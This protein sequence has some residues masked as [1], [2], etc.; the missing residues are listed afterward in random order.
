[1]PGFPVAFDEGVPDEKLAGGDR[2]DTVEV[3]RAVGDDRDAVEGDLLRGDDGAAVLGPAGLAVGPLDQVGG[4]RF[5]PFRLDAGDDA[6]PEPGGLD[7]LGGDH[8]VRRL[9]GERGAR[10]DREPGA[11]GAEVFGQRTAATLRGR[12]RPGS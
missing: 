9:A 4:D 8:P 12:A 11:A 5:D 10:E 1:M 7:E 3:H 2:V 6:A